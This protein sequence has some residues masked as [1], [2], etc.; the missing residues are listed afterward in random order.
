MVVLATSTATATVAKSR[1]RREQATTLAINRLAWAPDDSQVGVGSAGP[2]RLMGWLCTFCVHAQ[3]MM[4]CGHSAAPDVYRLC[5]GLWQNPTKTHAADDDRTLSIPSL[6]MGQHLR[7]SGGQQ[8]ADLATLE[9][10]HRLVS[11]CQA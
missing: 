9:A 1:L 2:L 5:F 3:T 6:L 11:A 8:I 4:N 10:Q 7:E